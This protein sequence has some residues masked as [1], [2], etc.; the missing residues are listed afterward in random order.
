MTNINY[1]INSSTKAE[2]LSFLTAIDNLYVPPLRNYQSL[3]LYSI[4]LFSKATLF[5]A[6][7]ENVLVALIAVYLND[8]SKK[9]GFITLVGVL[10]QYQKQGIASELLKKSINYAQQIGMNKIQLNVQKTNNLAISL[11]K[12]YGFTIIAETPQ[13]YVMSLMLNF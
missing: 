9:E 11:Y 10:P 1:T 7:M 3:E 12:K 13:D 4:K 5:E 8:L 6:Y 2:L